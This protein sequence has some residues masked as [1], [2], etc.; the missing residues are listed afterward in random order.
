MI[1]LKYRI[2]KSISSDFGPKVDFR[3]L[4]ANSSL[5]SLHAEVKSKKLRTPPDDPA[6]LVGGSRLG[7]GDRGGD[8][9]S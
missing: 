1:A 8:R 5:R 2:S 4:H 9:T 7:S 6:P 3:Q